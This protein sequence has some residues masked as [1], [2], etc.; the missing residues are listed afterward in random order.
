[1]LTHLSPIRLLN[2]G[3]K[4]I[5]FRMQ[6]LTSKIGTFCWIRSSLFVLFCLFFLLGGKSFKDG[7]LAFRS[8]PSLLRRKAI[9]YCS[10]DTV[11]GGR[12]VECDTAADCK[13]VTLI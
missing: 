5:L 7:V 2:L 4:S 12:I 11:P 10:M 1:M 13:V 8:L 3:N 6:S 9:Y